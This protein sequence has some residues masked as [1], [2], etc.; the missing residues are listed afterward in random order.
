MRPLLPAQQGALRGQSSSGLARLE[1]CTWFTSGHGPG[2]AQLQGLKPN[3]CSWGGARAQGD[4]LPARWSGQLCCQ[5]R[6]SSFSAFSSLFYPFP[7][8]PEVLS[9]SRISSSLANLSHCL[10]THTVSFFLMFQSDSAC[11]SVPIPPVFSRW[12]TKKSPTP[13]ALHPPIHRADPLEPFLQAKQLHHPQPFPAEEMLQ[14]F[15]HFHGPLP[16]FPQYAQYSCTGDPCPGRSFGSDQHWAEGNK[17][18]PQAG[19]RGIYCTRSCVW[20]TR[21]ECH[22]KGERSIYQQNWKQPAARNTACLSDGSGKPNL[23]FSFSRH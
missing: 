23:H 9:I 22:V 12:A 7:P 1:V 13:A 16:A 11:Q 20:G 8:F 18:L 5:C 19:Q 15:H 17:H 6:N 10:I 3:P 21:F 4:M 14:P 2:S